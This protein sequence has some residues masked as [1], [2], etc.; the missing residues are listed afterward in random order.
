MTEG[1]AARVVRMTE[2]GAA[3]VSGR[4]R[5]TGALLASVRMTDLA[6]ALLAELVPVRRLLL[7]HDAGDAVQERIES[8]RE[9]AG[10]E[11]FREREHRYAGVD[12]LRIEL[13]DSIY[14]F[15]LASRSSS[16]LLASSKVFIKSSKTLSRTALSSP[17][18][19]PSE[20]R[21]KA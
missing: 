6:L 3:R 20:A 1:G 19:L 17:F 7:H 4:T 2:G 14:F 8:T 12:A 16:F 9:E 15:A 11:D 18:P 13:E 5:R 21:F 10:E